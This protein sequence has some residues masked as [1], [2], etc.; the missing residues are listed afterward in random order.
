MSIENVLRPMASVKK[1][2]RQL[3][4]HKDLLRWGAQLP[5]PGPRPRSIS[6]LRCPMSAKSP[7]RS[8]G[9]TPRDMF[10]GFGM[11]RVLYANMTIR[12]ATS[13]T[14]G[15]A[16]CCCRWKC[17][18]GTISSSTG[19][20]WMR[21]CSVSSRKSCPRMYPCSGSLTR[22]KSWEILCIRFCGIFLSRWLSSLL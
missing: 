18:Q 4:L 12:I 21:Y 6:R 20:R 3:S 5:T 8:F 22:P 1:C 2:F 15:I 10:S 7:S 13:S 9:R 17:G 11:W 14:M 19:K 16:V